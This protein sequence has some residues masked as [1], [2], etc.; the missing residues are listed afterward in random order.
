MLAVIADI[1]SVSLPVAA[2]HVVAIVGVVAVTPLRHDHVVAAA[3]EHRVV[4]RTG[5]DEVVA[6]VAEDAVSPA[7]P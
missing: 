2:D 3:A 6:V 4:A 1:S 5:I 7:S